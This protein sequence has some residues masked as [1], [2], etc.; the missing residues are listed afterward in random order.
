[1]I[2]MWQIFWLEKF[3]FFKKAGDNSANKIVHKFSDFPSY[4][5]LLP[6]IF[7]QTLVTFFCSGDLVIVPWAC[8]VEMEKF[9]GAI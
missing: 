8:H 7:K 2:I 5:V 3:F 9:T 6:P 1:M 4:L